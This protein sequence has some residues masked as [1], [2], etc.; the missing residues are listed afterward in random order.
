M[1]ERARASGHYDTLVADDV[2]AHLQSTAQRHDLIVAA[3]LFIYLGELD[4]AFAGAR[5]V[6]EPGGRF[7][8]SVEGVAGEG[9]LL[10]PTLRYGHA[11]AYLRRL[12]DRHGL[13]WQGATPCTLREEQ[14]RCVEG[15]I[16]RL[17]G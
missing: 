14:R 1:V 8:F 6:L 12:A 4:A 13:A 2:V 5:R 17:D 15:L 7:V 9:W 10:R 11:E 3:D 16:V